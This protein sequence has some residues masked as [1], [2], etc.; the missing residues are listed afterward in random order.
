MQRSVFFGAMRRTVPLALFAL[1]AAL[2]CAASAHAVELNPIGTYDDPVYVTSEPGDAGRLYVVE[3]EGR[4]QLTTASGTTEFADLTGEVVAGGEQ[5][6][7]SLAFPPD[8]ASSRLFYVY[9]TAAGGSIR[10]AELRAESKTADESSLRN[11]IT[12]AH[13][14]YPNHNGGQVQFGPDGY[15]YLG[16]GDGGSSGDPGDNAQDLTEEHLGKLLRIDPRASAG[17]PYTVPLDN[18]FVG[19]AGDDEIWSYGLR[20][21]FR[22]SFDRLTGDLTI[23]DV[24]QDEWEEVDFATRASGGG[25]GVNWGW[26]CREGA[27]DFPQ[28]IGCMGAAPTD[29]VFEYPNDSARCA[30]TGG[31]VVRDLGLSELYGRYLYADICD[32]KIHSAQLASPRVTD[33]RR[34]LDFATPSSF[35]EDACGR[36]YAVSLNGTVSRFEDG[37]PTDCS[38]VLPPPAPAPEG[39]CGPIVS[40]GDGDDS[41]R[42][43]PGAQD[44]LGRGGSDTLRGEG[45]GD[46]VDGGAGRDVIRGG[47]G[48][49]DLR[50]DAGRDEIDSVDGQ[51]DTVACGPGRDRVRADRKDRVR[52]CER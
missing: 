48:R 42:G 52:G 12:I 20:N 46:C 11:V 34:E 35:G 22:F 7:L 18:P 21:P 26:D 50:G 39:R 15:L 31:Y 36:V 49:D 24:G 29:P 27:H 30:V 8:F 45:G 4:I 13:G 51:R 43:G 37:T 38:S 23:A 1:I 33:D 17:Q 16:T 5:G 47:D 10:V 19:I 9:Y 40:G 44:L 2:L 6:L 14:E 32:G 25:R 3:Q 41:L 28:T